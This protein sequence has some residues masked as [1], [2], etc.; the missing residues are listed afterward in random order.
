MLNFVLVSLAAG[1]LFGTMDALINANPLGQRLNAVYA[2]V[3]KKDINAAAGIAIDLAYGFV[4]AGVFVMLAGS[5]PGDSG[6]TK[7]LALGLGIW[8]FRVVM[9]VATTWMTHRVPASLLA[10]QLATGL[11]EMLVLGGFVGLLLRLG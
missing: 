3:M 5:L 6:L 7:G 8:F 11:A 4:I 2:P 1:L 10:Y 9:S